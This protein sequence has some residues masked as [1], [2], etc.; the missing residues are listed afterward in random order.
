MFDYRVQLGR[1]IRR[2]R[3]DAGYSQEGFADHIGVHRTFMG[4]VERG[5][6]NLSLRNIERIAGGLGLTPGEL[7][8]ASE[9]S[10]ADEGRE[11]AARP[12]GREH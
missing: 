3:V 2:L 10:S 1:T 12:S 5:E 6:S 7:L 8:V 4:T 9:R 11:G